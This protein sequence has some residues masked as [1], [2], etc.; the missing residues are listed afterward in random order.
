LGATLY[1]ALTGHTLYSGTSPQEM[2]TKHLR[3]HYLSPKK[4]NKK[5][6]LH[7]RRILR[8]M[9]AV[10]REKRFQ[11][12]EELLFAMD[13]QPL[14]YKIILSALA[15]VAGAFLF[16]AGMFLGPFLHVF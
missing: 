2:I 6:S 8:K 1:Y 14:V 3:G 9:L 11:N 5:I 15:V 12:M 13:R 7:T 16:T 4:F 10:N